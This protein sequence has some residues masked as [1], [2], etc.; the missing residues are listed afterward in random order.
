MTTPND[1][2][3]ADTPKPP[4]APE[5][6][7]EARPAPVSSDFEDLGEPGP[8]LDRKAPF[9]IG[10]MGASGALIAFWLL[11]NIAAIGNTLM[12]IVVAFFLAVGL[13]P[14]VEYLERWVARRSIAV[15]IVIVVVL[16]A[17]ALFVFAIV[18]VITEQVA[19]I[20]GQAPD[21]F[22]SVQR[23]DTVR[24][25][26]EEY[27]VINRVEEY[28]T[29][30]EFVGTLFGG[31]IGIGLAV[32]GALFNTFVITVLTLYF[33][34]SLDTTTNALFRLAPAS[35]RERVTKLGNAI[36][37]SVGH[38]VSGAF[39]V[40]MCAGISSVIF[41]FAVGLGESSR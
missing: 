36:L 37:R 5:A 18:P 13:N 2:S 17:I 22:D 12:L 15:G 21:W 28:V 40:A 27:D 24:Q 4:P 34:S 14:S 35:R 23:N 26:D 32:L 31:A 11:T 9:F 7:T 20:T 39:I 41:L 38:Y 16:G 33:L 30:G 3:V 10:F 19:S 29:D 25:L 6:G 8:P 1:D